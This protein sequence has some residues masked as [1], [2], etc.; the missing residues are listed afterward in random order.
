MGGR[1]RWEGEADMRA[2]EMGGRG[3]WEGEADGRA[4]QM[5]GRGR[6]E[7]ER[8]GRARQIGHSLGAVCRALKLDHWSHGKL[9]QTHTKRVFWG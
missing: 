4:R 6:W 7:G 2:R 5:G 9:Y 1:E 8:D 3:R